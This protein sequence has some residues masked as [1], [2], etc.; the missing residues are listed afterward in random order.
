MRSAIFLVSALLLSGCLTTPVDRSGGIGAR[1]V[2]N[3]NPS[4]IVA[5]AQ[6]AF[7]DR[8]YT[9]GPANF[10]D[11]VSFDKPSGA[12]S[13]LLWGSYLNTLSVRATLH[14]RPIPG[15]NDYRIFVSLARVT[16]A[17]QAGFEDS[18]RMAGVWNGEFTPILRDIQSAAAN[19]GTG[20]GASL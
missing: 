7:A 13:K 14:M 6:T 8:G 18:T 20:G 9:L 1:T 16:D 17:G 2:S 10:P 12:F 15:T 3:T 4:A 19:S 5:A 11:S